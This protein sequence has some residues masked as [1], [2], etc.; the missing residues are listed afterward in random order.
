MGEHFGIRTPTTHLIYLQQYLEKQPQTRP[1]SNIA[2][3]SD[4]LPVKKK[5]G[6]NRFPRQELTQGQGAEGGREYR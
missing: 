6:T 4:C 1:I 3:K 2:S 5:E